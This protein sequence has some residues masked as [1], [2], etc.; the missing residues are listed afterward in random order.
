MKRTEIIATATRIAA[1]IATDEALET[2]RSFS[3]IRVGGQSTP[4]RLL[5]QALELGLNVTRSYGSSETS[6]GCVYDGVPLNGVTM[7]AGARR[8]L[9]G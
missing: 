4:G 6:G 1:L 3:R 7:R 2:L 8:R 9:P 5:A